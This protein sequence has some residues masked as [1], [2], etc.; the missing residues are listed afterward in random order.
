MK[1]KK[2]SLEQKLEILSVS[3]EIGIVEACLKYGV[4]WCI[5]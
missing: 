5:L 3:E 1:Y 2:W 4:N